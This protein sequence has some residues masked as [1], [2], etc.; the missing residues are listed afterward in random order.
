MPRPTGAQVLSFLG[1]LAL[2]GTWTMVHQVFGQREGFR[3]WG[4]ALLVTSVIFTLRKQI[5]VTLGNR[6]LAPLEGRRKAYVLVPCYCVAVAV[7]FFPHEVACS[8]NL[9]GYVC[10]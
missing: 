8:V 10:P 4:I 7:S 2:A 3:F 5:P 9:R 1:F 6:E